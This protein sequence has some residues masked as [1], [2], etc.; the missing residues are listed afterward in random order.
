MFFVTR[1]AGRARD[2]VLMLGD[3]PIASITMKRGKGGF[4]FHTETCGETLPGQPT[5][6]AAV[7]AVKARAHIKPPKTARAWR[8]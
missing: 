3:L 4:E 2:L 8:A 6:R 5:L 7:E 1:Y